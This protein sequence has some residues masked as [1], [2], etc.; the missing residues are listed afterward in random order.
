MPLSWSMKFIGTTLLFVACFMSWIAHWMRFRAFTK[1]RLPIMR[2]QWSLSWACYCILVC[3]VGIS[4]SAIS[5]CAYYIFLNS[6]PYK[7]IMLAVRFFQVLVTSMHLFYIVVKGA[8]LSQW[9]FIEI[10]SCFILA[11]LALF[12]V[13]QGIRCFAVWLCAEMH[14]CLQRCS[15]PFLSRKEHECKV[16]DRRMRRRLQ[17]QQ[18][19]STSKAYRRFARQERQHRQLSFVL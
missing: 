11:V 3:L 4:S 2:C 1:T 10:G 13:I 6:W 16:Y 18:R 15:T 7:V 9:D 19:H 5:D 12:W 8:V 17:V 14:Q